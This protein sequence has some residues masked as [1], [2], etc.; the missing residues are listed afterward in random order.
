MDTLIIFLSLTTFLSF[1]L[2]WLMSAYGWGRVVTGFIGKSDPPASYLATFGIGLWIFL[3]GVLNVIGIAT[4]I[5][6]LSILGIGL[7]GAAPGVFRAAKGHLQ[8]F[9]LSKESDPQS[10]GVNVLTSLANTL[11]ILIVLSVSAYL[12]IAIVP[13]AAFNYHDDFH[14]YLVHSIRM[15][16][17]GSVVSSPF[18]FLGPGTAGGQ[19]FLLAFYLAVFPVQFVNILEP[20]LF[21]LLCGLL[22]N[23]F[24]KKMSFNWLPRIIILLAFTFINSQ[25]VNVS[26]SYSAVLMMLGLSYSTILYVDTHGANHD[27]HNVL[28]YVPILIFA[29]AVLS[30]KLTFLIFSG[31]YVILLSLLIYLL[32][33]LRGK[34]RFSMLG[35]LAGLILFL[36]PWI[37]LSME[38]YFSIIS[39]SFNRLTQLDPAIGNTESL[40]GPLALFSSEKLFWGGS[41]LSYGA[42]LLTAIFSLIVAAYHLARTKNDRDPN[43]IILVAFVT[44]GLTSYLVF[45]YLLSS[46]LAIRYSCPV[47]IAMLPTSLLLLGK[48]IN[49]GNFVW[50]GARFS[51]VGV[52]LLSCH[53]IVAY[54]FYDDFNRRMGAAYNARSTLSF[55]MSRSNSYLQY[56][57]YALGD[58]RRDTVRNLQRTIPKGK[59][60]F[61]WMATPFH[62]DYSRNNI[63]TLDTPGINELARKFN[64]RDGA[65]G[66]EEFLDDN[67][68]HYVIWEYNSFGM[69][70]TNRLKRELGSSSRAE[71][72]RF[73]LQLISIMKSLLR[74][75]ATLYKDDNVVV[76][77]VG[78][79]N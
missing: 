20:V 76:I 61:S 43:L 47:L 33:P 72:A 6:L 18:D 27:G 3:G 40:I 26:P 19:S 9:R 74:N 24:G 44:A 28:N 29:A 32:K 1:T 51:F 78:R 75:N 14:T 11:P 42:V 13:A 45:S 56:N 77:R 52:F 59:T 2:A 68:I 39:W 65:R 55:S 35:A 8:A 31:A 23:D 63:I 46:R 12:F 30:L 79:P 41:Y 36:S 58:A 69:R 25:Y 37:W 62:L 67:N 4:P 54:L 5:A 16:D 38:N 15:L 22:I 17:T 64:F 73:N 70:H 71:N 53:A 60:I 66:F 7:I 34:L 21:Y 57:K 49:T 10:R 48:T 50:R